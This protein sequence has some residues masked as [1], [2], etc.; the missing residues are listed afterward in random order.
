[1]EQNGEA[2]INDMIE[3]LSCKLADG[4]I[5]SGNHYSTLVYWC[6]YRSRQNA[7]TQ[8]KSR[9]QQIDDVAAKVKK[10]MGL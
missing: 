5:E 8:Q 4:T 10:E 7:N 3:D 1:M 2:L 6:R 9:F